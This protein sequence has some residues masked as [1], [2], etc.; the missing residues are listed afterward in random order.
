MQFWKS[1]MVSDNQNTHV[2]KFFDVI[3]YIKHVYAISW[4][5]KWWE[6][7]ITSI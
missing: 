5:E 2:Q 4:V 1:L 7:L 3:Y 6:I